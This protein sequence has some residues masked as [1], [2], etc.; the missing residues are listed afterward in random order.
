[1]I[2]GLW[3]Y[4]V[5]LGN[6]KHAECQARC[7]ERLHV[8]RGIGAFWLVCGGHISRTR[9]DRR[10]VRHA[11][12]SRD[13]SRLDIDTLNPSPHIARRWKDHPDRLLGSRPCAP[14]DSVST[15]FRRNGPTNTLKAPHAR[16]HMAS[17]WNEDPCRLGHHLVDMIRPLK[18][19]WTVGSQVSPH[20][21]EGVT[22]VPSSPV[23]QSL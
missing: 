11:N 3:A 5:G 12:R 8:L 9:D 21:E 22:C 15:T 2:G 18:H 23:S 1:M 14:R 10:S 19:E 20:G 4:G 13:M 6:S 7:G 16:S 17:L